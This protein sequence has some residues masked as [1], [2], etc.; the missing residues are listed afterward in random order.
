[1]AKIGERAWAVAA[2]LPVPLWAVVPPLGAKESRLVRFYAWQ[3][4]V[5]A[6]ILWL[7]VMALGFLAPILSKT[8]TSYTVAVVL[9]VGIGAFLRLAWAAVRGKYFALPGAWHIARW[10]HNLLMRAS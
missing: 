5:L 6:V 4:G 9:L 1:M 7:T 10:I 2:T 8:V 3:G